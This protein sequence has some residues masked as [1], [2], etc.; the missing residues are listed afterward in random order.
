[1]A[2]GR[3]FK[4]GA[5]EDMPQPQTPRKRI[6]P[7]ETSAFIA[8]HN[9]SARV[10]TERP[11]GRRRDIPRPGGN[12]APE[13]PAPFSR[14]NGASADETPAE[15][16]VNAL[17]ADDATP[18]FAKANVRFAS[19]DDT[20]S[21]APLPEAP[22]FE[23]SGA[24]E[25]FYDFGLPYGS[26]D[27]EGG[28]RL[29]RHRHRKQKKGGK[30]AAI[31]AAVV[32]VVVLVVGGVSG[33][34]LF[35]S[36]RSV[37]ADAKTAV[38]LA[39]GLKDKLTSGDFTSIPDDAQQIADLTAKIKSQTDGP[40]WTAASFIP[41]F[42]GDISAARTLVNTLDDV[43]SDGLIPMADAL[44]GAT[45]GQLIQDG[46]T[47]N[48]DALTTIMNS[49]AGTSEVFRS[50]NEEIQGIGDTHIAQVGE[51]VE[52]AQDGFGALAGAAE[53]SEKLAPLLPNMLGANGTRN[54][55]LIAEN[56]VEIRANGGFGG[57]Q[58]V[59]TVNNGQMSVGDFRA[60]IQVDDE[61]ALPVT[62][63]EQMLFNTITN[64]MGTN[65]GD[66][67]YTPDF[68]RAAS[69]AAQ[70]WEME[71][72]DRIDGVIALDPVFLQY[73]LKLVGGV[74]L[75][76]GTAVDGTNAAKVLMSDVY[77][78]Y[79]VSETDG[80]FASVAGAAFD[81]ILGNLGGV[82]MMALV[83]TFEQGSSE[84]RFIAWMADEQ[85]EDA[86]KDM[87]I[88]AAL[89]DASDLTAAPVTGVY[90]NNYSFSKLDWY[91]D[92]STQVGVATKSGDG[93]TN[94]QMTVKLTNTVTEEESKELPAYVANSVWYGDQKDDP[95]NERMGV[96][97]Y[98][99]AGGTITD[100]QV[101]GSDLQLS[102]ATHNGLDV[103]YGI[104]NLMPSETCTITYTVTVPAEA[105]D[106]PL[107][108]RSTP[109]CQVAREGTA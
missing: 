107:T 66:A 104:I 19:G 101:S 22:Q 79:P 62:D 17:D 40:L 93:S 35:N 87:G 102:A 38:S 2:D 56:N 42:G 3:H 96:Y 30:T 60:R 37:Q 47:I 45:P 91:L 28:E 103:Q 52:T 71:E 67:L 25:E 106:Q 33:F 39:T 41:V 7:G 73:M 89:P 94:Y 83:S 24:K 44:A 72:G 43:A 1:M 105:G 12:P 108:V 13:A 64:H 32:L 23:G 77:W 58:G 34:M 55:L 29:V 78:N 63:E 8:M 57:S 36:A 84:G 46:G 50:A 5:P 16:D 18:N 85:E 14:P 88:A 90:V 59:I 54:Y 68:P 21:F 92:L 98:A 53:A 95:G 81:K 61:D 49:L 80:I 76:D 20:S 31:V 109:T 82:D 6:D 11:T 15:F 74:E 69:M 65:T 9:A 10:N 4:G 86:L 75:P 48:V 26:S 70:L 99:P 100:V 97:L 51:L 27:E